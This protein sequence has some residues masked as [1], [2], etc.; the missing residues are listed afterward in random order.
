MGHRLER[1]PKMM[2]G[3]WR[4]KGKKLIIDFSAGSICKMEFSSFCLYGQQ[5]VKNI[6][7]YTMWKKIFFRYFITVMYRRSVAKISARY[8]L[9]Y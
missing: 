6:F 9:F 7:Q 5:Q 8:R 4:S 3:C 2:M 1:G